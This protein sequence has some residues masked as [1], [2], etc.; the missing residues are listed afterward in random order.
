M[1]TQ[2]VP[3]TSA[4][5]DEVNTATQAIQAVSVQDDAA[6]SSAATELDEQVVDDDDD[7]DGEDVNAIDLDNDDGTTA[8][9]NAAAVPK[10]KK[11]KAKGKGKAKALD[12]LKSV[13]GG[14]SDKHEGTVST[15]ANGADA[16]KD[17]GAI[18]DELYDRILAEARKNA[19]EE[20]AAKLDRRTVMEMIESE[21]DAPLSTTRIDPDVC[22]SLAPIKPTNYEKSQRA[23]QAA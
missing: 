11:K 5:P 18:S 2:S 23:G 3:A 20:A 22:V 13:L 16:S 8:T 4:P 14:G 19:G 15:T 6:A 21:Y 10:K 1:S 9:A 12:K 17:P 7:D